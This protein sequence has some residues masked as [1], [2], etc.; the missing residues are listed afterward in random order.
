[1]PPEVKSFVFVEISVATN[2][3]IRTIHEFLSLNSGE[4]IQSSRT[5]C[6][7]N[8]PDCGGRNAKESKSPHDSGKFAT[9][10]ASQKRTHIFIASRDSLS[11]KNWQ[12]CQ[13]IGN[14]TKY[15]PASLPCENNE[16]DS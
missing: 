4:Q 11:R 7:V 5:A 10:S 16:L 6:G 1:L 14:D 15:G 2:H 13:N 3:S 12:R 8:E 9:G